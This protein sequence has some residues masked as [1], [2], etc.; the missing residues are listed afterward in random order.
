M[1][2]IIKYY[3]CMTVFYLEIIVIHLHNTRCLER[4][5]FITT[6][7]FGLFDDVI[8]EFDSI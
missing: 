2:L 3:A 7:L 8:S 4:H 5:S 6:Q 1:A